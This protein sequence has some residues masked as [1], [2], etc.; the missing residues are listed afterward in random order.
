MEALPPL[1]LELM[2]LWAR[3]A[4]QQSKIIALHP[5][6]FVAANKLILSNAGFVE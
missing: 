4:T 3:S 5:T 6:P 1:N 2:V